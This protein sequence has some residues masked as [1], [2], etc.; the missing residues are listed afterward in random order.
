MLRH[1][2]VEVVARQPRNFPRLR[3]PL[4]MAEE[5]ISLAIDVGANSGQWARELRDAGYRGRIVSFEP[6]GDAFAKLERAAAG[7]SLWE[8]RRLAIGARTGTAPLHVS[9]NSVSSSLLRHSERQLAAEPRSA[10]VAT[11][12]VELRRLDELESLA[13]ADDRILLKADVEGGELDVLGGAVGLL[14]RTRLLELELSAIALHERQPLLGEVVHWCEEAGFELTGFE[15]SF[16]D[17]GTG[18]LFSGNGFFR[19]R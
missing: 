7:D 11:E 13:G 4:L 12:T 5:R 3:R 9:G 8:C 16:R 1:A 14:D 18:D 6:G 17:R 15:I 19:R 2:G 10:V